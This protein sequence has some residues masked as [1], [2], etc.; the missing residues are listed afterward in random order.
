MIHENIE[1]VRQEI[2]AFAISNEQT[3]EQFRIRFLGSKGTVKELFGELKTV[4]NEEKR[5]VGQLLNE[6]RQLAE[7]KLATAKES[8]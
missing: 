7:E 8:L 2:S 3:L 5:A 1:Q 6:L 4:P